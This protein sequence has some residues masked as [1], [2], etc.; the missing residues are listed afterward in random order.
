MFAF[1]HGESYT[2]FAYSDLL[3]CCDDEKITA[4]FTLENIGAFDGA[5]VAQLYVGLKHND[6]SRPL[7]ELK[8]FEK[9]FLA[10][11]EQKRV[12]FSVLREEL[13]VYN[14]GWVIPEGPFVISIGGASDAIALTGEIK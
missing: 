1:G 12:R 2:D 9:A 13:A 10:V 6:G 4:E 8:G 7:K 3:L 5:E 14:D 11:G